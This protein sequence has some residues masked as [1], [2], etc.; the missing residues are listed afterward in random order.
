[1]QNLLHR[2]KVKRTFPRLMACLIAVASPVLA[3]TTTTT[4]SYTGP[5]VAIPDGTNSVRLLP[6]VNAGEVL[7]DMDVRFDALPGCDATA[8]NINAA[9]DHTYVGDLEIDLISPSGTTVRLV[10]HAGGSGNNFCEA[11]LDDDGGYPSIQTVS[12]QPISGS[13]A[14]ANPLS[15]FDQEDPNGVWRFIVRDTASGDTGSLRRYSLVLSTRPPNTINVSLSGDPDP[16]GCTASSCS[17]REAVQLANVLPGM[18]RLVLPQGLFSV[19][20]PALNEDD[21]AVGDLDITESLQIV[22]AGATLTTVQLD[23]PGRLFDVHDGANLTLRDLRMQ[24][25]HPGP[26]YDYDQGGAIHM[27]DNGRLLVERASLAH[28]GARLRGGAVY[29]YGYCTSIEAVPVPALQFRDVVFDDNGARSEGFQTHGGAVYAYGVGYCPIYLLVANSDF[30]GNHSRSGGGAIAFDTAQS[31]SNLSL[32]IRDSSFVGNQVT[33]AGSGGAIALNP[34][35]NGIAKLDI[36]DSLLQQNSTPNSTSHFNADSD[37]GGA[38]ASVGG[39]TSIRIRRSMFDANVARYGGA[40]HTVQEIEI[41][42]STFCSNTGVEAG[43]ALRVGPALV[44]GST[45]CN[46]STSPASVNFTGGGAI[47]HVAGGSLNVRRST[48]DG[49]SSLRGGALTTFNG[50]ITLSNNT[51]IAGSQPAGSIGTVWL[52]RDSSNDAFIYLFNNIINGN[53]H[54]SASNVVPQSSFNNIESNGN[55]C[56]LLTAPFGGGNQ[57][58][59]AE[60]AINLGPLADNGGPSDTR[61]PIAPSVAINAGSN[62]S[63]SA[64]DQRGYARAQGDPQCDVGSVEV[65]GTV[66]FIFVDDFDI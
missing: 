37:Q 21:D 38:I 30:T 11:L 36:A 31:V 18:D 26:N 50:Q 45:F 40:I 66:D 61:L 5:A 43:G 8:G 60:S 24:S 27:P 12:V 63:C 57:V 56:R 64:Q 28:F 44:Q 35:A 53:C 10:D 22:G 4:V 65:G 59:V 33:V 15:A 52:H 55:T 3:Q 51:L 34:L 54:F 23:N 19:D 20:R 47:A 6:M 14:P 48:F 25:S 2:A 46:N 16:D 49:N 58:Q 7:V 42:D 32:V 41:Y 1:M 39:S 29:H 62:I 9:I 17:L 13:F